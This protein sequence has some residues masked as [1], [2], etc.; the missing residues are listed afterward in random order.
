[1]TI[2]W[3]TFLAIVAVWAIIAGLYI[4]P[5]RRSAQERRDAEEW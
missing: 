4:A 5:D 3:Q 1:M 2:E